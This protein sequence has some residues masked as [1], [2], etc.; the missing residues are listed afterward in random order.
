MLKILRKKGVM[1]KLLWLVAGVIIIV[2]GF[3]G[4]SYLLNDPSRSDVTGRIFGKKVNREEF[5]RT[6]KNTQIQ[7]MMQYGDNF[8]KILPKIG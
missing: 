8:S 2:F 5:Q 4:E 6:F 7:A 1:K 3:L